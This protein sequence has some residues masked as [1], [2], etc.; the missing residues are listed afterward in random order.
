M[1]VSQWIIKLGEIDSHLHFAQ[2][3]ILDCLWI[4]VQEELHRNQ[5]ITKL[6]DHRIYSANDGYTAGNLGF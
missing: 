3:N 1:V 6:D 2:I 4:L 5:H